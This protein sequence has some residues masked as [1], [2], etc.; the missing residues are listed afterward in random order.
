MYDK[1]FMCK[2]FP[3]MIPVESVPSLNMIFGFGF[4][5][6]GERNF[7]KQT[8]TYVTTVFLFIFFIPIFAFGSFRV[9][10]ASEEQSHMLGRVTAQTFQFHGRVPMSRLVKGWNWLV[11]VAGVSLA[12]YVWWKTRGLG[13]R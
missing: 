8:N 12:I 9:G 11:L 7:D 6:F 3:D 10:E 2:R 1:E 4:G 5:M 13:P